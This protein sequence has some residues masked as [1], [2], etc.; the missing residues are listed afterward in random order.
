MSSMTFTGLPPFKHARQTQ[1]ENKG[2]KNDSPFLMDVCH[3][4]MSQEGC[5]ASTAAFQAPSAEQRL[6]TQISIVTLRGEGR[7]PAATQ[8]TPELRKISL[9]GRS[10][11]LVLPSVAIRTSSREVDVVTRMNKENTANLRQTSLKSLSPSD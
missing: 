2:F 3:S 11:V 8:P 7:G 4:E 10:K 5:A 9:A 6:P 1:H